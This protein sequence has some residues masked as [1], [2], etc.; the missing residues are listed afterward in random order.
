[1]STTRKLR[2]YRDR[3]D[4][5]VVLD[6]TFAPGCPL[7]D[8]PQSVSDI[9]LQLKS[10][11]CQTD[12][13]IADEDVEEGY[14]V[15]HENTEY[16]A[17]Q[18][19]ECVCCIFETYDCIPHILDARSGSTCV[20]TYPPDRETAKDLIEDLQLACQTVTLV[21]VTE[22]GKDDICQMREVDL[23]SLSEK[24]LEALEKAESSG[25]FEP[26]GGGTL[27]ELADELGITSS[28]LSQ[29]ISRAE[30]DI[31]GQLFG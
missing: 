14:R 21:Q 4:L 13:V 15:H 12:F 11:G 25:Y 16:D 19:D 31:L 22:I 26:G 10:N 24:Q 27:E 17:D 1:M 3:R 23:A 5:R 6:I 8:P 29:R 2:S 30:A 18:L 28:A 9:E 7:N 20:A